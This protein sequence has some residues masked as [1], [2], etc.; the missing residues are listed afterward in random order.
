M[1]TGSVSIIMP[2]QV[3]RAA[4]VHEVT[5]ILK[6]MRTEEPLL[7]VERLSVEYSAIIANVMIILVEH[8]A[9]PHAVYALLAFLYG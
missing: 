2:Q 3:C 9:W 4:F 1:E 8:V 5:L 7:A 6:L